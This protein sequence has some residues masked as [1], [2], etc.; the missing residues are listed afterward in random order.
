[1]METAM[2]TLTTIPSHHPRRIRPGGPGLFR[3]TRRICDEHAFGPL[4]D[5]KAASRL[6]GIPPTW[7]LTQARAGRV[8]HHRL[9][10]YVRFNAEDLKQWL[11]DNRIA[12][13]PVHR[14]TTGDRS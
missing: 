6:L 3:A 11:A 9:G 4:L 1:M 10:L 13:D 14:A 12:P 2:H 8:P 7:L 5:A